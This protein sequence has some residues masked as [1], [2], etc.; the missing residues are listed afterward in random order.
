MFDK[1]IIPFLITFVF[2]I[3]IWNRPTTKRK[4]SRII[5]G[6]IEWWNTS[7]L[8]SSKSKI[9]WI[10]LRPRVLYLV[11]NLFQA[12]QVRDCVFWRRLQSNVPVN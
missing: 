1:S 12:C 6:H 3:V 11:P 7:N 10:I 8:R 5:H 9:N 2:I 4:I